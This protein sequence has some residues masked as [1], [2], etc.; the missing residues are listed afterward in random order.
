MEGERTAEEEQQTTK[1]TLELEE[2]KE[3][4][5]EEK[6]VKKGGKKDELICYGI[7]DAKLPKIEGT[8]VIGFE[9]A[10]VTDSVEYDRSPFVL[11]GLFVLHKQY[12]FVSPK[13][14]LFFPIFKWNATAI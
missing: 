10:K 12:Q 6:E 11:K 14:T 13:Y 2:A 7:V 4:K 3:T 9:A 8:E 1:K 5:E